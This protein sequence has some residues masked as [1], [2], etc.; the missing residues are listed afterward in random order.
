MGHLLLTVS[1]R[2]A[3]DNLREI[4]KWEGDQ[5]QEDSQLYL[6]PV[7]G[8]SEYEDSSQLNIKW[9]MSLF[10]GV[11]SIARFYHQNV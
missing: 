11:V 8:L 5:Q 1:L 7:M 10:D 9:N 2:S 6:D 3:N 4:L